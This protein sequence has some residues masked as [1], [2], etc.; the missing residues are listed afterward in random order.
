MRRI[1]LTLLFI[2]LL[3]ACKGQADGDYALIVGT[4]LKTSDKTNPEP[5][6]SRYFETEHGGV[7]LIGAN[8]GFYLKVNPREKWKKPIYVQIEYENPADPGAPLINDMELPVLKRNLLVKESPLIQFSSPRF[9]TGMRNGAEYTIV[10]RIF[11][12]KGAAKSIDILRQKFKSHVDASGDHVIVYKA[13]GIEEFREPWRFSFDERKWMLGSQGGA[14]GNFVREYVLEG[15]LVTN[16]SALVTSQHWIQSAKPY[17]IMQAM[18]IQI[19]RESPTTQLAVIEQTKDT[20]LFE[21]WHDKDRKYPAQHELRRI[22]STNRGTHALALTEKGAGLEPAK[23]EHW[24][25]LL[26]T[27]KLE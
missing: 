12:K 15:E 13:A 17:D 9:I 11:E 23:R 7:V 2:N 6:Q 20:V 18:M 1:A 21:W 3:L 25:G 16:W 5:A 10:V 19:V 22:T 27:A 14:N 4:A 8:A 24:I 26:R